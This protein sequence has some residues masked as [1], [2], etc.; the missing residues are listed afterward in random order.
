MYFIQIMVILGTLVA[1]E[2]AP[3]GYSTYVFK[4]LD[5]E[6]L[7]HTKYVML[8]RLPNWEH[9]DIKLGEIGYIDFINVKAGVDTWFNGTSLEYYKYDGIY[10]MKFVECPINE[11]NEYIL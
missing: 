11:D 9:R 7:K 6:I 3:F 1:K 10:F 4:C 5:E 2:A 8:T